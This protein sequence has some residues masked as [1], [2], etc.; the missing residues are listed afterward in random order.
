MADEGRRSSDRQKVSLRLRD[1]VTDFVTQRV[2]VLLAGNS[3]KDSADMIEEAIYA[4]LGSMIM[5]RK[6]TESKTAKV[7]VRDPRNAL[8]VEKAVS[9]EI[10]KIAAARLELRD[11]GAKY[12]ILI[13]KKDRPLKS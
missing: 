13:V 9:E 6:D 3:I 1:E 7:D 5:A 10:C 12:T 2:R 4:T 8:A 11:H